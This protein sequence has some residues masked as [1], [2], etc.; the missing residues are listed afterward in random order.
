MKI[1]YLSSMQVIRQLTNNFFLKKQLFIIL[2]GVI[3]GVSIAYYLVVGDITNP[4]S[5]SLLQGMVAAF[6]GITSAYLVYHTALLLDRVLPWK[7]HDGNRLLSGIILHYCSVGLWSLLLLYMSS[8]LFPETFNFTEIYNQQF[9]K[10]SI[11]LFFLIF[12][13]EIIYFALYSYYSFT[14]FQ[15]ES[16]RQERKR[17]ELQLRA[18]KSQLSPHFLFNSLNTISSLI[19]KDTQRAEHFVRELALMY[20]YI[21]ESYQ[22]KLISLEN[23]L[24]FVQSYRYLLE[25][26]FGAK[27]HCEINIKEELLTTKVPPL[28]IQ[29]LLENAVKHN[30]SEKDNPLHV[31]IASEKNYIVVSNNITKRPK[32]ITS[33]KI[34]LKNINARY[35]LMHKEGI[36]VTNGESFNV[37]V[38]I[39]S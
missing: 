13:F 29:M 32:H 34:G 27:F 10:L 26:R 2:S 24:A 17:I 12:V 19:Y 5:L 35:L 21:L 22:T 15:I 6:I 3:F 23:E 14:A 9:V 33:F 18:L 7:N 8:W 4:S 20:N 39:I 28:T 11:L 16:V 37:K 38:P 1:D 31:K 36:V 25:T 30:V